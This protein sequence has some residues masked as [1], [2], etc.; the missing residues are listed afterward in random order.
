MC[1]IYLPLRSTILNAY[2]TNASPDGLC[3]RTHTNEA[4]SCWFCCKFRVDRTRRGNV[5][6]EAWLGRVLGG[7]CWTLELKPCKLQPPLQSPD[8]GGRC[9]TLEQKPC[10]LRPPLQSPDL[11]GRGWSLEQKPCEPRFP[12]ATL[13]LWER[14]N[15]LEQQTCGPP[16]PPVQTLRLV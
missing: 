3:T 7:R 14:G 12:G 15:T 6:L 13:C 16:H 8:L 4:F 1:L 11:G 5:C 9:W 2:C 10:E